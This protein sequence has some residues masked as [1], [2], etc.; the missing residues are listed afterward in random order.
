MPKNLEN[1]PA[2]VFSQLRHWYGSVYIHIFVIINVFP[3]LYAYTFSIRIY[4]S[5]AEF[6]PYKVVT[7]FI[8]YLKI[9]FSLFVTY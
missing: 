4:L 3:R 9:L 7:S 2:K 6:N 8:L 5:S 1:G